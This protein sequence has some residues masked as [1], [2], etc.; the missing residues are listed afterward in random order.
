VKEPSPPP[1]SPDG[2]PIE[3]GA[4]LSSLL[5]HLSRSP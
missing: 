4:H 5:L 2:V 3:R 1:G